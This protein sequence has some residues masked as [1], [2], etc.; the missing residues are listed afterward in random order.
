M[1]KVWLATVSLLLRET[2]LLLL[3]VYFATTILFLNKNDTKFL[4]N[5]YFEG[6]QWK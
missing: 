6:P 5:Y 3:V 2:C 1:F 4:K